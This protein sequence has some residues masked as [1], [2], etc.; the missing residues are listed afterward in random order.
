MEKKDFQENVRYTVTVRDNGKL[1]PANIYVMR[2]YNDA[3]IVRLTEREGILRKIGYADVEKIVK[4]TPVPVQDRYYVPEAVLQEGSW[5][6]RNEI[7]HYSSSPHA[8]K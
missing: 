4:S 1:R 8:G 6:E 7:Q 5:K 3:M 2:C